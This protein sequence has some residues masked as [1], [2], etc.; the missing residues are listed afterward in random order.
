[1]KY[2]HIAKHV[3]FESAEHWKLYDQDRLSWFVE[4]PVTN[5]EYEKLIEAI[6]KEYEAWRGRLV[7]QG[8][9]SE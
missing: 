7:R 1:M 9:I 8:I 6:A 3:L 5:K 2:K 4:R